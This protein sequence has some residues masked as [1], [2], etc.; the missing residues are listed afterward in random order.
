MVIQTFDILL[1][2]VHYRAFHLDRYWGLTFKYSLNMHLLFIKFI[3]VVFVCVWYIMNNLNFAKKSVSCHWLKTFCM[4]NWYQQLQT[5]YSV[6][7]KI[8]PLSHTALNFLKLETML[9]I[10]TLLFTIWNHVLSYNLNFENQ[11]GR[12]Q[13]LYV[14]LLWQLLYKQMSLIIIKTCSTL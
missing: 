11:Q 12:P 9:F 3:P 5:R 8:Y 13:M 4:K 10:I 7:Y 14:Q 2:H 1:V 6:S